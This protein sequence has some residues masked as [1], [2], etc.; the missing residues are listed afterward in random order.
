MRLLKSVDAC[1]QWRDAQNTTVGFVP[2]MGA[3]HEGHLSLV[4]LSKKSCEQT[5][6]SIFLNPTQF[7]E[8]E[9]LA[10]YPN[11]INEDLQKLEKENVDAVFIPTAKEM[12]TNY[13]TLTWTPSP[14]G[15]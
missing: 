8:N 2:T 1:N 5:L 9:D 7:A 11:T 10:S 6:V 14:R 4:R 13:V 15:R 3:L 12:Y